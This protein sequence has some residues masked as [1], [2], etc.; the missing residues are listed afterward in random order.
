MKHLM[1][2]KQIRENK[3]APAATN[4]AARPP[5][6]PIIAPPPAVASPINA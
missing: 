5:V 3:P 1:H 6:R 4:G 2:D